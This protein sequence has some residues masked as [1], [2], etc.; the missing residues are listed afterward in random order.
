M[1]NY[2]LDPNKQSADI[3]AINTRGGFVY[4]D[5]PFNIPLNT[6]T[7]T[8]VPG[9]GEYCAYL[10]VGNGGNVLLQMQ[11]GSINPFLGVPS[12]ALVIGKG[13]MVVG[14]ATLDGTPYM[15]TASNITWHG[16]Q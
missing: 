1:S 3:G 8:V 4:N 5:V 7:P 16:G 11:D 13:N 9:E 6:A 12:G 14:S 15:T 2:P 10:Y